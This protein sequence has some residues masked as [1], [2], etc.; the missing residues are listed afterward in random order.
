M[1]DIKEVAKVKPKKNSDSK[2]VIINGKIHA[3]MKH[4]CKGGN[5]K[6]GGVIENLIRLYLSNPREIENLID[7]LKEN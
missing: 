2:S 7:N 1:E 5:R 6:L 3:E 4:F